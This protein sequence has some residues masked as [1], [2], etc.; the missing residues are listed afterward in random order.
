MLKSIYGKWG[1]QRDYLWIYVLGDSID[2]ISVNGN[3]YY[4]P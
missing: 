3:I 1:G 2:I 4:I